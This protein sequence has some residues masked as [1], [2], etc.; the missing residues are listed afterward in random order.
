MV[1]IAGRRDMIF[2][3]RHCCNSSQYEFSTRGSEHLL[4]YP[5]YLITVKEIIEAGL[6]G[7]KTE[8]E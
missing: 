2:S 5:E 4:A 1:F 7:L 3:Y 8:V 6:K